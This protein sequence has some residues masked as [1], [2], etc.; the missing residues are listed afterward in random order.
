VE[1]AAA[2]PLAR[3]QARAQAAAVEIENEPLGP[4]PLWGLDR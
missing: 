4:M 1:I 2:T 3:P